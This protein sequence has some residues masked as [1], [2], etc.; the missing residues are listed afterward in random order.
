LFHDHN[1]S[2]DK[3]V[4]HQLLS[5]HVIGFNLRFQLQQ[6]SGGPSHH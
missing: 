4:K 2:Q 5:H 6:W 1:P 3:A